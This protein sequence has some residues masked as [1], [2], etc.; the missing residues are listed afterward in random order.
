MEKE[1]KKKAPAEEQP[2]L[3]FREHNTE[4]FLQFRVARI[5]NGYTLKSGTS[6]TFYP[7]L[8][9]LANSLRDSLLELEKAAEAED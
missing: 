2:R 4:S 1:K 9:A 6:P 5:A 3:V 8:T 7:T